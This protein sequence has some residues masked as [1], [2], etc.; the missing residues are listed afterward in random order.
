MKSRAL[1]QTAAAVFAV[2]GAL[3]TPTMADTP[4]KGVHQDYDQ[5]PVPLHITQPRYPP[6]AFNKGISGTVEL[7]I[8]IDKTGRVAKTR[9]VRSIPELDA[10]A[11]R[12]VTKWRFRPAQKGGEPV[13]SVASAPV[14]FSITKKK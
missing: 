11:I 6:E 7:E 1:R 12:C 2:M 4:A 10:A 5:P 3:V 14:T 9:V 13:A 8:L